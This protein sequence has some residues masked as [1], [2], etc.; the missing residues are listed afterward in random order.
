MILLSHTIRSVRVMP[1]LTPRLRRRPLRPSSP[2][3][4]W[5]AYLGGEATYP[6]TTMEGKAAIHYG[7][8]G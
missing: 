2:S 5:T 1:S 7:V 3:K 8:D 4:Y 6:W